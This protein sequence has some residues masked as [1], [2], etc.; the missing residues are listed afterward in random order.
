MLGADEEHALL[1]LARSSRSLTLQE[2]SARLETST[3]AL[4]AALNSLYK[5]RFILVSPGIGGIEDTYLLS[6]AAR[7]YA[8]LYVMPESP[9]S[10]P[11]ETVTVEDRRP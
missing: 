6:Q 9:D 7:R 3:E 8:R 11:I 2:L 4:R 10:L 1:V 5:R